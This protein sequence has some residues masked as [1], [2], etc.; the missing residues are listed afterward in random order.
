MQATCA[1][2]QAASRLNV[3]AN[4]IRNWSDIYGAFLSENARPGAQPERRFSEHDITILEYI[5]RLKSEG[6]K[7]GEIKDRLGETAFA[8]S[9]VLTPAQPTHNAAQLSADDGTLQPYRDALGL[10]DGAPA[11]IVA[12]DVIN[13]LQRRVEA[14]EVSTQAAK[15]SQRD[16]VQGLALGFLAACGLFGLLLLLAVLYGGF[17]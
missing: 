1:T 15:Q 5:K 6:L 13:T 10:P 7:E 17:R 14:V 2:K 11:A 4:T 8:E 3:T 16:Y 9:E 12:L